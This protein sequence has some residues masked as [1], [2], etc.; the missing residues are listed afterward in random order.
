MVKEYFL[1]ESFSY[2]MPNLDVP[3]PPPD[4]S[5]SEFK[6]FLDK[7]ILKAN[8]ISLSEEELTEVIQQQTNILQAAAAHTLGSLGSKNAAGSLV[9]LLDS[10]DDYVGVEAAYALARLG[11]QQGKEALIQHL[12]YPVN[13][14]LSPPIAA[15][16]LAILGDPQGFPV[17]GAAFSIQ[18]DAIRMSACKR[19]FFFAPY[20]G[21]ADV[22]GN[23]INVIHLFDRALKDPNPGIQWQALVQLREI[24]SLDIR[25][26]VEEYIENTQDPSLRNVAKEILKN[27][28]RLR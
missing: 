22:E 7:E 10:Q 5:Y 24:R 11:M 25:D 26:I 15:G 27:T 4:L 28:K 12:S 23:P 20:H 8:G 9:K 13:A 19:L 18:N 17:I 6:D 21:E 3:N 14:Y 2:K 16:Y 1:D